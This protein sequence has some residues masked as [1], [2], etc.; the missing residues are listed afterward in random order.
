MPERINAIQVGAPDQERHS[1]LILDNEQT[2][3]DVES[4]TFANCK[5]NDVIYEN[6]SLVCSGDELLKCDHGSWLRIGSCDQ[7]N[8]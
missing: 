8:P 5:F 6:D 1:S 2:G 7:D 4:V 3:V